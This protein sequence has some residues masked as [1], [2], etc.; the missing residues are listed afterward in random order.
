MADIFL[1]QAAPS[2]IHPEDLNFNFFLTLILTHCLLNLK[3]KPGLFTKI[4]LL[5]FNY[6]FNWHA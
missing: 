5:N 6:D 2:E 1:V 3:G 4:M